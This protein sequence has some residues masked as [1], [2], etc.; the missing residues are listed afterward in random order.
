MMKR[1]LFLI[2]ISLV[3]SSLL[4]GAAVYAGSDKTWAGIGKGLAIYEG[5]K[6][7]TG[8]R[9]NIVEDVT[10]GMQPSDRS[11]GSGGSYQDGYNSGYKTGY[12]AGYNAGFRSGVERSGN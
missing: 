7:L 5:I 3:I 8:R 10:G 11:S 2:I 4:A 9:G 1:A 12:D 6:V